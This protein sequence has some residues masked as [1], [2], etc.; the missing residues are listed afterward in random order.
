MQLHLLRH[1]H[2][3]DWSTWTGPDAAR[4]LTDKGRSQAERLGRFLAGQGF[5]PDAI[6]SSPKVRAAQTAQIVAGLLDVQ[7]V[8]DDRLGG[9]LDLTTLETILDDHGT[10]ERPVL[11]GHDPDFSE[12]VA[13]LCAAAGVPMRKG[14]LARIEV[15]RPLQPGIGTLRWLVPPDLLKP[16]R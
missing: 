12:L 15:D 13:V 8:V 6:I 5:R 9:S 10:P 3:G 11:V 2:A 7:V 14:S 1:A 4:P 16:E